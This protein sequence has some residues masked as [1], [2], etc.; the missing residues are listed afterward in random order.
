MLSPDFKRYNSPSFL[1]SIS[2]V[3]ILDALGSSSQE[4]SK[5]DNR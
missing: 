2:E 5:V 4:N 3:S 1:N